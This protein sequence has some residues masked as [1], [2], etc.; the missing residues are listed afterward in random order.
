MN[1]E[2]GGLATYLDHLAVERGLAHNSLLAYRRDLN[3]YVAYL[4]SCGHQ[5]LTNVLASD[6]CQYI[7]VL[8]SG[9]D[10]GKALS[11][12]SVARALAAIRGWHKFMALEGDLIDAAS[13]ISPPAS[14]KKLPA[15]LA[16]AE[17]EALLHAAGMPDP[18]VGLRDRA[19]LE[20]CYAT[21]A[22]ISEAV[23]TDVDDIQLEEE[24]AVLLRG[25][26]GKH[27]I[28]PVGSFAA[29]ALRDYLVRARP[30]LAAGGK[31]NSGIFLNTRGGRLSRQSAWTIIRTAAGRAGLDVAGI[32]PHILR[33][34]FATHLLAGGADV[35][36]V[37][38][39][40]GHSSLTTT[41]I[42]THVAADTLREVYVTAHPRAL[43]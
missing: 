30:A 35:R 42:Y 2:F 40:L 11:A 39:L 32:S 33:H 18:P 1:C 12:S 19:L 27:R 25:K 6:I 8:R 3:R 5:T 10:G 23:G 21:G 26:G 29:D 16:I 17:V 24:P 37:Q 41:Q 34:S 28:V 20:L 13:D 7:E 4:H 22:R 14:P 15:T 9:S 43:R 36:V 31:G 38:E